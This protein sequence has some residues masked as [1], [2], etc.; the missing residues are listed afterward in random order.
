M[1][2]LVDL[3]L[4]NY[5]LPEAQKELAKKSTRLFVKEWNRRHFVSENYSA[6]TGTGD[7]P[8]IKSDRFYTWGALLGAITLIEEGY[9][10]NFAEKMS[11]Q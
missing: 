1:N 8:R 10:P 6:I 9:M 7:G 11:N 4:R 5:D 3:G 2:F